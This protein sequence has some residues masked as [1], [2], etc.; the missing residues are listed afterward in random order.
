MTSL[1]SV[2]PIAK[3]EYIFK[4][5]AECAAL[6]LSDMAH[7]LI[8]P[9]ILGMCKPSANK[10]IGG[11]ASST[12][13]GHGSSEFSL[14]EELFNL[15]P[16]PQRQISC[17][18]S[19]SLVK[20]KPT[21]TTPT[22]IS[23]PSQTVKD[24]PKMPPPSIKTQPTDVLI[25]PDATSSTES[26]RSL[27]TNNP[28][29]T[30]SSNPTSSFK[31]KRTHSS[32]S[33]VS[34]GA[35][36]SRASGVIGGGASEFSTLELNS[37]DTSSSSNTGFSTMAFKNAK[38]TSTTSSVV[39]FSGKTSVVKRRNIDSSQQQPSTSSAARSGT[40]TTST[41]GKSTSSTAVG[42]SSKTTT[43]ENT[44]RKRGRGATTA[45]TAFLNDL[46]DVETVDLSS[47]DSNAARG[48]STS[49]L[50]AIGTANEDSQSNIEVR[51]TNQ[52]N[53]KQTKKETFLKPFKADFFIYFFI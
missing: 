38:L 35:T 28:T 32:S 12:G 17:A 1:I 33:I 45:A 49:G 15:D 37:D 34:L 3:C 22:T 41:R 30:T 2:S 47:E 19:T 40:T 5:F 48:G 8:S 52:V 43:G 21:P 25:E 4:E 24:N 31:S 18:I 7:G 27:S 36:S 29:T 13:Q 16:S 9:V 6:E 46:D 50:A 42:S 39:D 51:K 23:T 20:V 14:A 53:N 26:E 11:S 10:L 44:S